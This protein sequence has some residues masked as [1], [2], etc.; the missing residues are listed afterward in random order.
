ME[1]GGDETGDGRE[2]DPRSA[3]V[4]QQLG[5]ALAHTQDL[6]DAI[7]AFERATSIDPYWSLN[8]AN[9]GALD[10]AHDDLSAARYEWQQAEQRA[11]NAALFVLHYG[12]SLEQSGENGQAQEMYRQALDQAPD[13]ADAGF[14]EETE[15]RR[16]ARDGWLQ[17]F[18]AASLSITELEATLA[19]DPH[20]VKSYPALVQAYLDA[21]RVEDAER[22]IT[23][24]GM[25][26]TSLETDW[27]KVQWLKAEI[28]A[29]QG[30]YAQAVSL[31]QPV[32]N[33]GAS[34]WRSHPNSPV[35]AA[36]A[37]GC[38]GKSRWVLRRCRSS[39]GYGRRSWR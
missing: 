22:T 16:S 7:A 13:W 35:A 18:P 19:A 9:L 10:E 33:R 15:L 21:G 6:D 34:W 3:I 17:E 39:R 11:P 2:R 1:P 14:W 28:A 23:Q 25:A 20:E 32:L 31:G 30:D 29:A 37:H 8:H 27:L 5:L 12:G 4:Q 26:W 24:A 38:S 36:T